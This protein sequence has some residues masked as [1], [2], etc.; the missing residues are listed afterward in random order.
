MN[1]D[2]GLLLRYFV[3]K[4]KGNNIY[5]KASREAM[6]KYAEVIESTNLIF[7]DDLKEWALKEESLAKKC[8]ENRVGMVARNPQN[9]KDQWYVARKYFE[10]NFEEEK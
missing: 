10:D 2:K 6:W 9:H 1:K 8:V 5:A 3:I 7:A 4:P